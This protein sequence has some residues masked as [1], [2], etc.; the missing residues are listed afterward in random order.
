MTEYREGDQPESNVPGE[1]DEETSVSDSVGTCVTAFAVVVRHNGMIDIMPALPKDVFPRDRDATM[2]DIRDSCLSLAID[3][4]TTMI[5]EGASSQVARGLMKAAEAKM[6]S[7]LR[8]QMG[9][10]KLR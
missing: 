4:A 8:Q 10:I 1:Q 5:V 6:V 3:V 9:S 2:R 7:Q